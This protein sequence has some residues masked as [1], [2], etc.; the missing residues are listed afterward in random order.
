[1][2]KEVAA[3]TTST[4][5]V[6]GCR[7]AEARQPARSAPREPR[8]EV[9]SGGEELGA[10]TED[11]VHGHGYDVSAATTPG[12]PTKLGFVADIEGVFEI[13]LENA[14]VEVARLMVEPR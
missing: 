8:G 10:D 13:E 2:T 1:M 3:T 6:T 9:T 12:K 4:A 5:V 14:G 11:E 7:A